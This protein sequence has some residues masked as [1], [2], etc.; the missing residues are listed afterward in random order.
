MNFGGGRQPGK[1]F[2]V[3]MALDF[4]CT[5]GGGGD[6]VEYMPLAACVAETRIQRL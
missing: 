1:A 5:D 3:N 2:K 6:A 4:Q